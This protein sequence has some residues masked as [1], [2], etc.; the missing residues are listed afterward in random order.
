[1]YVD[2][3]T[4]AVKQKQKALHLTFNTKPKQGICLHDLR[5]NIWQFKSVLLTTSTFFSTETYSLPGHQSLLY[6]AL[7][8]ENVFSRKKYFL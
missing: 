8:L 1:M 7:I 4:N 5:K 6:P 3:K 2:S